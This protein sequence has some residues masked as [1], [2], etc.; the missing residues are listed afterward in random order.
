MTDKIVVFSTTGSTE[1]A[2]KLAQLL[3]EKRLAACVSVLPAAR[4]FYRWQGALESSSECLLLIKSRRDLFGSLRAAL[5]EAHSYE[6]PE[7]L[8]LPV[9]DGSPNYLAWL[10][11]SLCG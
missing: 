11:G 2:E 7:L 1:E 8:A 9:V 6:V 4:S 5:E 3:I 10:E